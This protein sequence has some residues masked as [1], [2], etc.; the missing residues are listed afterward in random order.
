MPIGII[1]NCLAVVIGGI[2]GALVGGRLSDGLKDTLNRIFGL[3]AMS[4]GIYSVVMMQNMPACIF[5]IIMGTILG[6]GL[7]LQMAVEKGAA[8]MQR[9]IARIIPQKSTM[10]ETEYMS[11]MITS[12]CLFCASSTGI[13]GSMVSRM[14]G[15]HSILIAKS[16]LDVFTALIFACNL[17]AV[18]SFIAIPQFCI[19][20]LMYLLAGLIYPHTTP[21][22]ISDF[23]AVGGMIL[24]ATGFRMLKVK[25]FPLVDMVPSL[26]II[27]PVSWVWTAYVLPLVS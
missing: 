1:C 2:I 13:Y 4:M 3:C 19:F 23:K 10:E 25:D 17:G 11:L 15:D 14:S 22:M 5:S 18:T 7:R 20:M 16:I 26:A 12:I 8:A 27:F 6:R 24:V 9:G 21:V